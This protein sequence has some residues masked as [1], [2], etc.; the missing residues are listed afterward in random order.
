MIALDLSAVVGR[1]YIV[2]RSSPPTVR[3][4]TPNCALASGPIAPIDDSTAEAPSSRYGLSSCELAYCTNG[5]VVDVVLQFV[6][7]AMKQTAPFHLSNPTYWPQARTSAR[8]FSP[9]NF[10]KPAAASGP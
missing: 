9:K 4:S 2:V 5:D 3:K 10:V 6:A 8:A 1:L 7:D